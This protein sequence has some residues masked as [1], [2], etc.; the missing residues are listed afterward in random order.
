MRLVIGDENMAEPARR[1]SHDQ[2][3]AAML[4]R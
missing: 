2:I 1:F 4:P 3:K